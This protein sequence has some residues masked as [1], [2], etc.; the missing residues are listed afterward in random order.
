[1]LTLVPALGHVDHV[2]DSRHKTARRTISVGIF[3]GVEGRTSWFIENTTT[4][5]A[6]ERHVA[7]FG[8]IRFLV[9]VAVQ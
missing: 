6:E 8:F 1:M 7:E 2:P 4:V 9:V 5:R 3:K